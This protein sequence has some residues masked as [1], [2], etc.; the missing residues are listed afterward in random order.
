VRVPLRWLGEWIE[1]PWPGRESLEAFVER[2]TVG[3]L[4]IDEV[5]RTGPDLS[6]LRV[7]HVLER[8]AHP[9]ADKL[10]V[11]QVDLG[12]GEA[13]EIV[14]GAP[15]VAAGQKVAVAAHGA[16]LPDGGR[17]KRS[18]I[19]GVVSN[20]M[21]CSARELGLSD[22]AEGILVLAADA[23]P[24]APLG[25]VLGGGDVVL[26]VAITPNRGDWVSMLGMAREVRAHY[27]GALRL[28][29]TEPPESEEMAGRHVRVRVEDAAGCPRYAARIVRGVQV[30]PS[31]AWLRE[32]L[33]AAGLRSINNVV[34][35]TNLVMLELGQPLHAFDLSA[36][37]GGE[38][39]VRAARPGER[40]T[41]LDGVERSLVPED[42]VIADAER[43]LAIA[44]VMGG[45]SSEVRESTCDLL[46]ES[47]QFHP[48]RVRATARRLGLHTDASYRFERG[49]DP[50][51]VVRAAD[52]AARLLAEL[53]GAAVCRGVVE[54]RGEALARPEAIALRPERV[55]RLLGTELSAARMAELLA[56]VDVRAE[57]AG[58]GVLR[59][60][61]P[62]WR[63][64]LALP[65]DLA[66][67][68]ARLHGYDRIEP[69]LPVAAL[70][71]SEEPPERTLR[72]RTRDA[73][74]GAGLTELMTFPALRPA[75]LDRLRLGADD[76]RR[77]LVELVNPV[78]ADESA[79]RSSLVPSLLRAAQ[80]NLSR[81]GECLR[82]FEVG[83]AFL[84]GDD[85]ELPHERPEAAA[86]WTDGRSPALWERRD[87][88]VFYRAK[89]AAAD[90]LA[91]LGYAASFRA[92]CP[93]PFLHPGAS[94][95]LRVGGEGVASLGEIHPE[96]AAAFGIEP[97][98][99]LLVLDLEALARAPR[100]APRYREISRHP[101]V[102][103][104]LAV[105]LDAGV[106]AGDVLEWIRKTGGGSL[107]SVDVFDRYEGRGVPEGKVSVA[108]RL[109]FQRTDR[110]LTD[111]EVARAVERI[112]KE[113]SDR[114]GGELR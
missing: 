62:S 89:G 110:T 97:A 43:A 75:D 107:Q 71:G 77:A 83:R 99:A 3:G 17:I 94:G 65:E 74:R 47:A 66:E 64:D 36:V 105:L 13:V 59:C 54:A 90:L 86:L 93:E 4:E 87:V 1:L 78:Q 42:L 63:A 8:K 113:L 95:E 2:L 58:E 56:R 23:R 32:R 33:E 29:P 103:R 102:R 14:C 12:E 57:P 19:R 21:I 28:P 24:G 55:N 15:N 7:G 79:L 92:G 111:A 53:A 40:M 61:A 35:V 80:L 25:E 27:G 69:T 60:H 45:A 5:I 52:R 106:A 11:C 38:V 82:L 41:S 98:A 50:E 67:E 70:A 34:D 114:F 51:G 30:G 48:S 31:P 46:I 112:V 9:N 96:T 81:Q 18:K 109:E 16:T 10:S 68:V 44:G 26:D 108:F 76:P 104:D 73:L 88:P 72:E 20:G 100:S 6:G 85:G 49:V 91:E 39:R 84:A 37:R 22:E 101:K